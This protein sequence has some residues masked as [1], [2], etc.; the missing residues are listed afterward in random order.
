MQVICC[1]C[2]KTK[3]HNSW[4]AKRSANS[5]DQRSH[6]Y[7]PGCYQQMMERIENFFVMN[8][9]RKSA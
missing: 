7:C 4:A 8:S 2:H 5:G 1:V 6:G 3:K 9:C